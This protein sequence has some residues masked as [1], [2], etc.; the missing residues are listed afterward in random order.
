MNKQQ[1]PEDFFL[2]GSIAAHQME[3]SWNVD[4]K[5]PAIMDFATSGTVDIPREFTESIEEDKHYPSHEGIDFYNRYK[6][7]IELFA[8][9][10]F[11]ALRISIDWSRIYPNGDELEP[12]KK[13]IDYYINVVNTLQS[14]G[15]EPIVTLY[16]FEMPKN[17][18][19]KYGSWTNKEVVKFYLKYAETMFLALKGKVKYW[20]TFNEMNHIDPRTEASDIFTY[21]LA[22]LKYTEM[23][24]PKQTLATIGYHMT[25]AGVKACE[26]GRKVDS[27]NIMGCVFGLTPVYP[28]NS[29]PKVALKALEEMDRDFY[30]IDAMTR[31]FYPKYKIKEY[32]KLGIEIE[33]TDDD[34]KS[35]KNG[36]IDFIGLN[37]Y[38]SSM[39]K[40]ED[41]NK[42]EEALFS[43]IQ[44]PLLPKS[45]WGWAID[46]V[47]L[48][49]I[50]NYTY[51]KYGLPIIVTENGL[52]AEDI[53]ES[54][55]QIHDTYRIDYLNE[56]LSELKKAII[57]DGVECFGYLMWGPIDLVSATTGEMKKRYGFIYVNKHDNGTGDYSR[58][59]KDSYYWFK[60][61]ISTNGGNIDE[62]Q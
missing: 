9:M 28:Y 14:Y 44:N 61:V 47:G 21:I 16:H 37:Y 42:D 10:G 33:I 46:P 32:N 58:I 17:L 34:K 35:F 53:L 29:D 56:H 62:D 48:R 55:G 39:V 57:E 27:D 11:K 30:Q 43:G 7:D 13:G 20:V 49:Y 12:N 3:G 15:I 18:V 26:L 54:D 19:D 22:G 24:N 60:D 41:G 6:K 52:G 1:F 25:L 31:G 8:D 51:R 59:P 36:T 4:G 2:G 5:G 40:L 50:V 38:S 45:R 23:E